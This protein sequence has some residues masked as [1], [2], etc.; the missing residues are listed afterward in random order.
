MGLFTTPSTLYRSHGVKTLAPLP[1]R[2]GLFRSAWIA[3][4]RRSSSNSFRFLTQPEKARLSRKAKMSLVVLTPCER[5]NKHLGAA[6]LERPWKQFFVVHI[7]PHFL[8]LFFDSIIWLFSDEHV[9]KSE[10]EQSWTAQCLRRNGPCAFFHTRGPHGRSSIHQNHGLSVRHEA[11]IQPLRRSNSS[12]RRS[13][14]CDPLPSADR[15]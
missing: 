15:C 1:F 14:P 12:G 2:G 10:P 8:I 9:C 5:Y 4:I 6:L 13:G 7:S 3:R 11:A